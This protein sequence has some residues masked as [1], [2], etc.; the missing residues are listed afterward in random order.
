MSFLTNLRADRL[1]ADIKAAG[2]SGDADPSKALEK[3]SRLGPSAIP[4]IVDAL[5]SAD[6]Q[7]TAGFVN[8][9]ASL[10]DNKSLPIVITGLSEG[11]QRASSAIVAALSAARGYTP[12]LLLPLLDDPKMPRGP[13]VSVLGAQK[14]K[15][16]ARDLLTRAY[17]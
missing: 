14:S 12:Q 17:N 16:G 10:I 13:I 9:L 7:E 6:R 3:L 8:V 5:A 2:S 11:N 4:R 15:L 1:I